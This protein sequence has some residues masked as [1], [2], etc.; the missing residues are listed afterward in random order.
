MLSAHRPSQRPCGGGGSTGKPL[1]LC[2]AFLVALGVVVVAPHASADH[3]D[4][5][6][7]FLQR[8]CRK[9]W[10]TSCPGPWIRWSS[11]GN[12]HPIFLFQRHC[13]FHRGRDS[14]ERRIVRNFS[15]FCF[16]NRRD[17][18]SNVKRFSFIW[19]VRFT[20]WRIR[21]CYH[22]TK[23]HGK[24]GTKSGITLGWNCIDRILVPL[25]PTARHHLQDSLT[26]RIAFL[27]R[28]LAHQ[29]L[30]MILPQHRSIPQLKFYPTDASHRFLGNQ[31]IDD[32]FVCR[33]VLCY[34]TRSRGIKLSKDCGTSARDATIPA[35]DLRHV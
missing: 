5:V 8:D 9:H 32:G 21:V 11:I 17:C 6:H 14:H 2:V 3:A 30:N 28:P 27:S 34:S 18:Q 7:N 23:A 25:R 15:S 35:L 22:S 26:K 31:I 33:S 19:I 10:C 13:F 1:R 20:R 4:N 29:G 12:P 24:G 16:G